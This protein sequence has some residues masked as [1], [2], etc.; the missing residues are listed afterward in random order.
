VPEASEITIRDLSGKIVFA[1]KIIGGLMT[2]DL[3]EM[4]PGSY[5]VIME[6]AAGTYSKRFIKY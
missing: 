1:D 5:V 4:A 6:T 2:I 3:S